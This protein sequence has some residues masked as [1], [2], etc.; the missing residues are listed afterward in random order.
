M[1]KALMSLLSFV[2]VLAII[3]GLY[4]HVFGFTFGNSGKETSMEESFQ[5]VEEIVIEGNLFNLSIRDGSS[6]K[7]EVRFEGAEKLA[8]KMELNGGK[9]SIIQPETKFKIK[10]L[11][12]LSGKAELS[13]SIPKGTELK[14]FDC[15]LDLGNIEADSIGAKDFDIKASLGNVEIREFTADD[16]QITANLGDVV[17]RKAYFKDMDIDA[18][19]GNVELETVTPVSEYTLDI[20]TDLGDNEVEGKKVES[21]YHSKGSAGTIDIECDLGNVSVSTAK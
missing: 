12:E 6:D 21:E 2:T 16:A 14:S 15:E 3:A 5:N 19:L 4:I 20:E 1:N 8:P 7:I 10:S 9:L 18:D 11:K 17:I 13:I